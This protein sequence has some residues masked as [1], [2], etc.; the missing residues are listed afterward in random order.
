MNQKTLKIA[1]VGFNEAWL[2]TF[3][4]LLK[5]HNN[6]V[7]QLALVTAYPTTDDPIY[8]FNN[9]ALMP[10]P[11]S[12][13]DFSQVDVA[14]FTEAELA[15][16]YLDQALQSCQVLDQTGTA[17]NSYPE[18]PLY[19]P[20]LSQPTGGK[21]W[22]LADGLVLPLLMTLLPLEQHVGLASINVMTCQSVSDNGQSGLYELAQQSA[23]LLAGKPFESEQF[24][25]Q[26]AFNVLPDIDGFDEQGSSHSERLMTNYLQKALERDDISMLVTSAR[27]PVFYSHAMAIH[28]TTQ[29]P[30]SVKSCI[31]YLQSI[32]G[33]TIKNQAEDYPTQV[34]DG[35]GQ[36]NVVVGRLRQPQQSDHQL[37]YWIVADN[38]RQGIGLNIINALQYI[39]QNNE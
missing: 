18:T 28:V 34:S 8:R 39:K 15:Q 20:N 32:P 17:L 29:Q 33:I 13:F 10:Q 21:V 22:A 24:N 7:G 31:D 4:D 11:I 35:S 38:L 14:I 25:R 23:A 27:V 3:L 36:D 26:M 2:E 9:Q 30:V 19:V 16:N 37:A 5:T 6:P 1:L 12:N